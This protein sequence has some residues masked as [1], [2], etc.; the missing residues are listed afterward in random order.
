MRRYCSS[1][2]LVRSVCP[3]VCGW[4][5][6][7]KRK[8]SFQQAQR[9]SRQKEDKKRGITIT[10]NRTRETMQTN[11]T[12]LEHTSTRAGA[13]DVVVV[14]GRKWAILEK[15]STTTKIAS[16]SSE[17]GKLCNQIK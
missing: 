5:A 10:D 4:L 15:R 3:S 14:V 11:N 2:R 9:A 12:I 13:S 1:V 6:V 17:R 7:E 16:K 8:V